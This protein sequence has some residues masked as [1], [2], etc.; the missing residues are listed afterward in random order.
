MTYLNRSQILE[1]DDLQRVEVEVPEWG[2]TLLV[3]ELTGRER[4]QLEAGSLRQQGSGVAWQPQSLETVRARVVAMA[5]IDEN[6]APLFTLTDIQALGA[7]SGRALERVFDVVAGISGMGQDE[8][9]E[10]TANFEPG[11]SGDSGLT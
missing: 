11:P 7:K 3:R 9:E 2:G 4:G 1:S 10:L 8:I 5:A 6:G